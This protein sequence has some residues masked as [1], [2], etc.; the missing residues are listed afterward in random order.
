[1]VECL[2]VSDGRLCALFSTSQSQEVRRL[3]ELSRLNVV[4]D[5]YRPISYRRSFCN[6]D[7]AWMHD[8]AAQV[9]PND[10]TL[11]KLVPV[12]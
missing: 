6:I 4:G 5:L 9:Y 3:R 1:M 12:H 11:L 7:T 8:V 2:F 10:R